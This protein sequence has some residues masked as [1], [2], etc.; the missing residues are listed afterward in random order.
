MFPECFHHH[1]LHVLQLVSL[2]ARLA[3]VGDLRW[4]RVHRARG[5][6]DPRGGSCCGS[7][8]PL[9]ALHLLSQQQLREALLTEAWHPI[10]GPNQAPTEAN[11][12]AI[13]LRASTSARTQPSLP[14]PCV[15]VALLRATRPPAP[16][17]GM[18]EYEGPSPFQLTAPMSGLGCLNFT[19]ILNYLAVA[20]F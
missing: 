9:A 11:R 16:R 18:A 15:A 1:V 14:P 19:R 4:G 10:S 8:H 17:K 6:R 13:T 12:E 3:G 7:G 20:M 2:S 5:C